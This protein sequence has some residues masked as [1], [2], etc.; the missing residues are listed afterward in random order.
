MGRYCPKEGKNRRKVIFSIWRCHF[1]LFVLGKG[2]LFPSALFPAQGCAPPIC[3][4][5]VHLCC[6]YLWARLRTRASRTNVRAFAR[7]FQPQCC[8][9]CCHKCHIKGK[10]RSQNSR[11]FGEDDK[12]KPHFF[13][14]CPPNFGNLDEWFVKISMGCTLMLWKIVCCENVVTLVTAKKR[15]LL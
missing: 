5:T 11:N 4:S 2:T 12:T 7:A 1:L 6:P 10:K 9:F 13:K 14:F 3:A 8:F 15:K